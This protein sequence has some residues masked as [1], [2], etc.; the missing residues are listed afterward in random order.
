MSQFNE[1]PVILDWIAEWTYVNRF[2]ISEPG[3]FWRSYVYTAVISFFTIDE[4]FIAYDT[5]RAE[6]KI[7]LTEVYLRIYC[8]FSVC[9]AVSS[10]T[11][12]SVSFW[13]GKDD[14]TM[15]FPILPESILLIAIR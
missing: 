10:L 11:F 9:V 6:T 15:K 5:V 7:E 13:I 14:K 8:L 2:T 4:Y 1:N 12:P 3:N